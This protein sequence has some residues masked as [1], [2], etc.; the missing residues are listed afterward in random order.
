[1]SSQTEPMALDHALADAAATVSLLGWGAHH[2]L[3][4]ALTLVSGLWLT[5]A[6][7]LDWL[8]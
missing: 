3:M 1:M 5:V 2:R 6:W 4:V 7:A 8:G